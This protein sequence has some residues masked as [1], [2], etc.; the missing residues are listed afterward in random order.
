MR[1]RFRHG[2]RAGRRRHAGRFEGYG[3]DE[4]RVS[5]KAEKA[6][7]RHAQGGIFA[8]IKVV[9]RLRY[10]N[11]WPPPVERALPFLHGLVGPTGWSVTEENRA[12]RLPFRRDATAT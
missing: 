3:L 6:I 10:D 5:A 7:V 8:G 4:R 12:V 2:E 1:S 9:D 11:A